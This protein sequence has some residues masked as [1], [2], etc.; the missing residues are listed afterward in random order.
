MTDLISR[1]EASVELSTML[2]E[3]FSVDDE[4]IDAV[5]TTL[6]EIRPTQRWIPVSEMLPEEAGWFLTSVSHKFTNELKT[7]VRWFSTAHGFEILGT[8]E[9]VKAW[10]PLPEPYRK[11]AEE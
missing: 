1:E 4:I 7:I 6:Q 9:S 8:A 11:E 2:K 3:C 5:Q 10:M